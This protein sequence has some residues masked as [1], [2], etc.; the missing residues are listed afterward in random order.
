MSEL[1][2]SISVKD[3]PGFYTVSIDGSPVLIF[4]IIHQMLQ[5]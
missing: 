5:M 3:G 1:L 4:I 2:A